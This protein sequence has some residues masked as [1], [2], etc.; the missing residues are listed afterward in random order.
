MAQLS[1][2]CSVP[3]CPFEHVFVCSKAVSA[4][5][6]PSV[7]ETMP[8]ISQFEPSVWGIHAISALSEV[9][10]KEKWTVAESQRYLIL[11]EKDEMKAG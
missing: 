3:I 4:S 8:E 10:K 6:Q 11:Y 7:N 5:T 9:E 1:S 2:D